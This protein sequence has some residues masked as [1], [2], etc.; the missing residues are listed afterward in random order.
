MKLIE[1]WINA[2]DSFIWGPPLL[3]LLLGCHIFL[4]FYLK[5]IQRYVFLGIRLSVR[6]DAGAEGD[7]S[8]FGALAIARFGTERQPKPTNRP[9]KT[10]LVLKEL[11]HTRKS[12]EKSTSCA[13]FPASASFPTVS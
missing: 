6:N 8:Q 3:I 1:S 11:T 5:L 9:S 2:L 7:I 12:E 10:V 4:T 13:H